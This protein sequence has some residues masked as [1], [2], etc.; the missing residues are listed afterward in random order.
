MVVLNSLPPLGGGAYWQITDPSNP[1]VLTIAVDRRAAEDLAV[2]AI[3]RSPDAREETWTLD[4]DTLRTQLAET[5]P[6]GVRHFPTWANGRLDARPSQT[7]APR[8]VFEITQEML[9]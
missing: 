5:D 7:G 9:R 6:Q 3:S 8:L 2:T 1:D 4:L